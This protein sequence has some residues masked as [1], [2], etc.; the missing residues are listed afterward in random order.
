MTDTKNAPQKNPEGTT[1]AQ[2]LFD[3]N[4]GKPAAKKPAATK[5]PASAAKKNEK[6]KKP[7]E[8]YPEDTEI[9]YVGDTARERAKLPRKMTAKEVYEYMQDD[10]PEV[11]EDRVEL[12]YDKARSRIVMTPKSFKKG[13]A[14][15]QEGGSRRR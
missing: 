6:E 1:T 8:V 10:Y 9:H 13:A 11:T 4:P 12:R 3:L 15:F 5:A 7:A 14:L 2:G